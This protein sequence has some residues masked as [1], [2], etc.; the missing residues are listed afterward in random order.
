MKAQSCPF[1]SVEALPLIQRSA[2][3][4][5]VLEVI[6]CVDALCSGFLLLSEK[7]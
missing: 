3:S 4:G 5:S 6:D 1:G 7:D 2:G